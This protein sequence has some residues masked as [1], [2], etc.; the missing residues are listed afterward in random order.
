MSVPKITDNQEMKSIESLTSAV[1]HDPWSP[2]ERT[3]HLTGTQAVIRFLLEALREDQKEGLRTAAFV[4]GY[5]GSPLGGF[6]LE[7]GRALK[8]LDVEIVHEPGI[9]E[10]LGA[11]A[12][13]GSQ[14]ASLQPNA[15]RDGVIGVWYGKSPGLDRATDALRHASYAGA[16]A[17]GGLLVLVG[18]DPMAK[19]STLPSAG[20]NLLAE[21]WIPVLYPRN[22]TEV[23]ELGR[24]AIAMSRLTGA[25]VALKLV[26]VI[27]DAEGTAR[28]GQPFSPIHP[29]GLHNPGASGDLLTPA[30][31][32]REPLVAAERLD[33]AAAYGDANQLNKVV[34]NPARP[35]VSI[36]AAGTIF[37][38]LREALLLLGLDDGEM[39]RRGV[40]LMEISMPFPLGKGFAAELAT[41]GE[42]VV[43]VEERRELIEHQVLSFLGRSG[44]GQRIWGK[45]TP[46]GEKFFPRVGSLTPDVIARV[47]FPLLDDRL[48]GGL[49]PPPPKKIPLVV[50]ASAPRTPWYCS[51]CPH[52]VSTVVPDGHPVGIGIGCHSITTY[53]PEERVGRSIGITQMGGE[54]VQWI[55]MSRFVEDDHIF[56]N[57]GDSTF[58]H[59]GHLAI[60]ASVAAK[61][62]ITYKILWN[63]VSAMTGGQSPAGGNSLLGAITMLQA[64]GVA[65]IVVTTDDV[66]RTKALSLPSNV[67]VRD[68]K[69]VLA[70]QRELAAQQGVTVMFHDQACATELRRA[71]KRGLVPTPTQRVV[72]NERVCEGCGDC[73]VK[74]NCL[75]LQ[76]VNT[77]FGPKTRVDEETCNIDLSCLQGDCPAF[78]LV[79]GEVAVPT[80]GST[81]SVDSLPPAPIRDRSRSTTI[82]FAGI[83]GTGVVTAAHLL[84]RAALLDGIEAW[85]VDQTGMSQKAGTVVSDLRIGPGSVERSNVLS[86]NEVDVLL[87]CDLLAATN[88][89]V[90]DGLS[91]TRTE[92]VGST[93][94]SLNGPMILGLADRSIDA[95]ALITALEDL[96]IPGAST[97]LDPE[98]VVTRAGLSKGTS[99]V[100]L[101]GVA[102]QR[103]LLPLRSEAI[104]QAIEQNGVAVAANLEAFELGRAFVAEVEGVEARR[105]PSIATEVLESFE[106]PDVHRSHL[107]LLGS[108]L[109]A[110]QH[111]ALA[112]QFL[113]E[114]EATWQAERAFG[115]EGELSRAAADGLYKFLAYKDEYEVARLLLTEPSSGGKVT[116]LLHPPALRSRGLKS[117]L[118]LGPRTR[119]LLRTLRTMRRLRGTRLDPFGRSSLR[120]EERA[121]IEDY[122]EL[123]ETVRAGLTKQNL[124]AAV[125]L[126]Q[127]PLEVRGYEE[128]K[129]A[130][131]RKYRVHRD[132]CLEAFLSLSSPSAG[133]ASL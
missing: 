120:R 116:W 68:R 65:R 52:S 117:K 111:E 84:A 38:E 35:V 93:T 3:V 8:N 5:Q 132:A 128:V 10:E 67:D 21:L 71:R 22:L 80:G 92:I 59:S 62:S 14:V 126:C 37:S 90:L 123:L 23:I 41:G 2:G 91:P 57:M 95:P 85:G 18:D 42:D 12:V 29:D 53:M 127:L 78:T 34:V 51:G 33:A 39:T 11:T 102:A 16:S 26:S 81:V 82:R 17:H 129:E 7:L 118:H 64:E 66:A 45:W 15:T 72:I 25:P 110:Y 119:P 55:G 70:V 113:K 114:I 48:G 101:I 133:T 121:L 13:M 94:K 88:S 100:L 36:A 49:N 47:L 20:E 61:T 19:S 32:Q 99:N 50:T 98:E 105:E 107:A 130:S 122:L 31:L 44:S 46:S 125:K 76:T 79:E 89:S 108:E 1:P 109:I 103:G 115:G 40:K 24:H 83:G 27:A 77:V 75:S 63:G 69:D 74:S 4:S 97:F 30:T 124:E 106:L 60:R 6:D 86:S 73:Q 131:I 28:I 9:N 104:R 58:F 112:K 87:A 43:I 96:S 54:G 56:Q